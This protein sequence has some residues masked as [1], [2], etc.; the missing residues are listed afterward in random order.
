MG[1]HSIKILVNIG[2]VIVSNNTKA[3]VEIY[4]L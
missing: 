1:V 4:N 2:S 3:V